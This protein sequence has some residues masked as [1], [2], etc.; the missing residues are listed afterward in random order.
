MAASSYDA[1]LARLLAHE[2]GYSD[3]PAD[4]GGPTKFGIT[5][6]VYRR[7][8]NPDATAADIRALPAETA[9]TIYRE[10]YWDAM[11]CDDLPAGVDYAVFDYG[12][13][14]GIAR[15]ESAATPSRRQ[16]RR[17]SRPADDGRSEKTESEEARQRALRRA[18]AFP[19]RLTH[20]AGIRQR[21]DT[22]RGGCACGRAADG[23]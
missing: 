22:A 6:A 5:L 7:C 9:K 3:H 19:A 23:R 18:A 16:S 21:L 8:V 11:R 15:H 12:V 4:P 20:L 17:P 14:S 13:N 1:A 10:R 2:G